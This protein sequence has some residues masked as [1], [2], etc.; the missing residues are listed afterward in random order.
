MAAEKLQTTRLIEG[1]DA[2]FETKEFQEV[3]GIS[4]EFAPFV[5]DVIAFHGKVDTAERQPILF[6]KKYHFDT[7][8]EQWR[9][10]R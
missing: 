8:D 1:A 3:P 6:M 5:L 7:T 2:V 10:R 9:F 4:H